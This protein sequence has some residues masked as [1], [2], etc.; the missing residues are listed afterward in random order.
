LTRF[1]VFV[2]VV[3]AFQFLALGA[4]AFQP[5]IP[6]FS[7]SA[8]E[9]PG[10]CTNFLTCV[11]EGIVLVAKVLLAL[12]KI[13][14]NIVIGIINLADVLFKVATFQLVPGAPGWLQFIAG[15]GAGI[16][17]L[18]HILSSFTFANS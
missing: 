7:L 6:F 3:G 13:I 18:W 9:T 10:E 8:I 15:A 5:V 2:L 14:A 11:G 4:E 17:V 12:L 1:V 16:Y